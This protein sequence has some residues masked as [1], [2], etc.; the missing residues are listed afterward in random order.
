VV[1]PELPSQEG[2]ARSRGTRGSN[3]APLSGSQSSEPWDTWQHRSSPRQGGKDRSWET[4][5]SAGVHF[6]KEARSGAVGNMVVPEPTSVGR[7]DPKL[8]LTWQRVDA[9][10]APCVDLEL[11]CEGTRSSGYPQ[12]WFSC[13]TWHI[14][15]NRKLIIDWLYMLIT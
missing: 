2:R 8:Q 6:S 5:G 7:F 10:P 12:I 9:R 4:R 15:F 14:F 13:L 1:A 3:G 11:V